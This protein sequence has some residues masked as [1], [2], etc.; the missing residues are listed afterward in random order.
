VRLLGKV[1]RLPTHSA[2]AKEKRSRKDSI[3]IVLII[4]NSMNRGPAAR[5]RG[6]NRGNPAGRGAAAGRPGR[7]FGQPTMGGRMISAYNAVL[8]LVDEYQTLQGPEVD[9]DRN[10]MIGKI[11]NAMKNNDIKTAQLYGNMHRNLMADII[12]LPGTNSLLHKACK[13]NNLK[14]VTAFI[15]YGANVNLLNKSQRTPLHKSY[16]SAEIVRLLIR[17]KARVN[18]VDNRGMTP[19]HRAAIKNSYD[20]MREL[21][22]SGADLHI[23]DFEG[24]Q[25]LEFVNDIKLKRELERIYSWKK[26]RIPL[27]AYQTSL[28]NRIPENIFREML[29]FI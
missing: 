22:Q 25:P 10:K 14:F 15:E 12:N 8:E 4:A 18:E 1:V 3:F 2:E 7:P 19:L 24:R 16:K 26:S 13:N 9:P 29:K 5:G 23:R 27:F 6:N 11:E 20:V 28:L 17:N 21:V